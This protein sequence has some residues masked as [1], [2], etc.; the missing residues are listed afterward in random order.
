MTATRQPRRRTW[1]GAALSG[2]LAAA[3]T[4]AVAQLVAVLVAPRAAPLVAVGGAFID[5]TP[6]ALKD[7]AIETFGTNDKL[8]LLIGMGVVI[9]VA[10]AVAGVLARRRFW[11]GGAVVVVLAAVGATAGATRANAGT[12]AVAPSLVG[13]LVGLVA[14]RLLLSQLPGGRAERRVAAADELRPLAG[15]DGRRVRGADDENA[16][17]D[18]ATTAQPVGTGSTRRTFLATALLT[19]AFAAAA[20]AGAQLLS[21]ATQSVEAARRALRLPT[22][23]R[24]APAL[25]AGVESGV[26]GAEPFVTPNDGFYRIDTALDIPQVDASTWSVRV[27]GMV[28][29]EI[30]ISYQDLLDADLVES[31]V[32][33][34]CVSNVVGGDLAGNAKWLGL[35]VRELLARARPT[36]GADMVLSTSI[37][38]F[39]ASTPLEALTDDR[40]A[41]LAIGMND[42]PLPA[43]HGYPV[44]MVVPGLYGFVSATKWVVDLE[45]TRYSDARAYWTDR[46]WSEKGPIKT[47]SRIEVPGSFARLPAGQVAVGGTAWAQQ[48]GITAVEVKVDGG[49]WQPATLADEANVDTWRQWSFVWDATP[50]THQ[51]TVRAT[52]GTGEVQTA[53]RVDTVPDG[54]TGHHSVSVTVE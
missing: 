49:D 5:A 54:S 26:E 35:P 43:V 50:G 23:A 53:D 34:T 6:P 12:F 4:L 21:Q 42:E 28:E 45:V 22:P 37:D 47:A 46:G 40:D 31:W 2:V 41:L 1:P 32:T 52:D 13:G 18:G 7:F 33:L 19:A 11:L 38:G 29:E 8:V 39:T 15:P 10:A 24:R 16:A 9:A 17:T 14:L 20:G 25:P 36:G 51:L 30:E 3:T 48:R 27:H 44:R